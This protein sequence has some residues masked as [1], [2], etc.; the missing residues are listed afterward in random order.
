MIHTEHFSFEEFILSPVAIR[1]GIVNDP[2][3][4]LLPNILKTMT[5]LE[6]IRSIV[7]AP[8]KVL[9]GYRCEELNRIIGGHKSSQHIKGQAAD[10]ICP[11]YGNAY[12]LAKAILEEM[13]SC[14]VDKLILEFGRWVHVS[15]NDSPRKEVYT[16]RSVKEGYIKGLMA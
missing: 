13:D 14:G 1:N 4:H 8:I 11:K 9:S 15:F 3:D 6:K 2:P 5:G 12:Q 16:I 10:I 7:D